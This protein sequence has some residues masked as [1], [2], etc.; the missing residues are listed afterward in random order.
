MPKYPI[1]YPTFSTLQQY[2]VALSSCQS[3]TISA[4]SWWLYLGHHMHEP[5]TCN[6]MGT[7]VTALSM[8]YKEPF[9][10]S[11]TAFDGF[12]ALV[13]PSHTAYISLLC[14]RLRTASHCIALAL[15]LALCLAVL[16]SYETCRV[17]CRRPYGGG[18]LAQMW[19][20]IF[21]PGIP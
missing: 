19:H 1:K 12:M 20:Q 15:C 10:V 11:A 18:L 2:I 13:L 8:V 21:T 7:C 3:T 6:S 9:A 5:M 17:Y 14:S 4:C 16:Y